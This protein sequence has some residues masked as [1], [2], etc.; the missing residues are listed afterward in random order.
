MCTGCEHVPPFTTGQHAAASS[1]G[2]FTQKVG[3]QSHLQLALRVFQSC[4]HVLGQLP[5]SVGLALLQHVQVVLNALYVAMQHFMCR[6]EQS[7]CW[8]RSLPFPWQT[9]SVTGHTCAVAHGWARSGNVYLHLGVKPGKLLQRSRNAR[10]QALLH[11]FQQL[12]AYAS[13]LGSRC[14]RQLG[15]S[16]VQSPCCALRAASCFQTPL[17][18]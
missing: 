1:K 10:L 7:E 3:T 13:H 6:F 14:V 17:E 12:L 11:V 2:A 8:S 18:C 16:S 15:A 5:D 4:H 9:R